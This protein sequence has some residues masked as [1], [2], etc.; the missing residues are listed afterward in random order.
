MEKIKEAGVNKQV[1]SGPRLPDLGSE[2][3]SGEAARYHSY[4]QQKG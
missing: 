1:L 2:F 3:T 4:S